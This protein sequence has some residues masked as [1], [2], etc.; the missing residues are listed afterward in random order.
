MTITCIRLEHAIGETR[1]VAWSGE[2]PVALFADP[3]AVETRARAGAHYPA[4]LREKGE[5]GAGWFAELEGG[6]PVF[7]AG[8]ST[9]GLSEG[10]Q[11]M[12]EIRAEARSGKRAR[13]VL[14]K[15][16]TPPPRD[17]SPERA[18]QAWLPGA[19]DLTPED[20]PPGDDEIDAVFDEIR[21]SRVVL[22][23]GGRLQ[24][25][26][27]PA[28]T[29]IDIDTA[30]RKARGPANARAEDLNR[31]AAAEAARQLAL[32]GLGG[33]VVLDC[34]AGGPSRGIEIG[35]L[36]RWRRGRRR[37][38]AGFTEELRR[39]EPGRD[40]QFRRR[41]DPPGRSAGTFAFRAD[42]G[43]A[44]LARTSPGRYLPAP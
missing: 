41:L 4:R 11:V 22:A 38:G 44:C 17:L 3:W 23:G 35:S 25:T 9:R 36:S 20:V 12:L 26:R 18:W 27:T 28:L 13:G 30:G 5:G 29:A 32:R 33:L 40:H 16:G 21:E 2:R 31:A 34:V 42:G 39:H 7:V 8:P 10:A 37:G 19:R 24:I 6:E 1:A 15:P 14:V 43:L